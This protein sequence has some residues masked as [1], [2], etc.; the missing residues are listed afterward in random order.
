MLPAY[1][2]LVSFSL[3]YRPIATSPLPRAEEQLRP[4]SPID[5]NVRFCRIASRSRLLA[6]IIDCVTPRASGLCRPVVY[7]LCLVVPPN[8]LPLHHFRRSSPAPPSTLCLAQ[9]LVSPI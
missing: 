9:A 8:I 1:C 3:V 2:S 5:E 4:V 7:R 6:P